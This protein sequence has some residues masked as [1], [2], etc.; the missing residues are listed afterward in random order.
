VLFGHLPRKYGNGPCPSLLLNRFDKAFDYSSFFKPW[1]FF[2]NFDN[3]AFTPY[4]Q[5]SLQ[6]LFG[7]RLQKRDRFEISFDICKF[8]GSMKKVLKLDYKTLI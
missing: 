6:Y 1:T 7:E 4:K 5:K 3:L 8:V 2:E